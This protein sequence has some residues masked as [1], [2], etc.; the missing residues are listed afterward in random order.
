MSP[1]EIEEYLLEEPWV[2]VRLVLASGDNVN[3]FHRSEALVSGL[4]LLIGRPTSQ[5][6]I[7]GYYRLVSVPN[8]V[9]AERTPPVGPAVARRRRK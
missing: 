4:S 9:L 7:P 1:S 6:R 5:S 3:I 8:I 2:P